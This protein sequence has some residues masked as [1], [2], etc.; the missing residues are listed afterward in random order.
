MSAEVGRL[1][2]AVVVGAGSV[3]GAALPDEPAPLPEVA[4]PVVVVEALCA[5]AEPATAVATAPPARA[6]RPAQSQATRQGPVVLD[7]RLAGIGGFRHAAVLGWHSAALLDGPGRPGGATVPQP[8]RR[9][10]RGATLEVQ[11]GQVGHPAAGPLDRLRPALAVQGGPGSTVARGR[12]AAATS[13]IPSQSSVARPARKPAPRVV[14]S[15]TGEI[16]TTRWTA[17]ATAWTK[18]GLAL[19]PPSTRST[20]IASPESASAASTRS[21]PRWATP[22]STAR[23]S[24]GRPVP[25]VRP[26][27]VPRAPKSQ[28]G[29]AQA[30]QGGDVDDA[31]GVG[32][33]A[34]HG[35]ALRGVGQDAEVVDQPFDVGPGREHD[36]LGPPGQLAPDRPGHDGERAVRVALRRSPAPQNRC[37]CRASRPCR[38]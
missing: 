28:R 23:T 19:I 11:R 33:R 18:V 22:S 30:Q 8:S 1:G 9:W 14:A 20:S 36:R 27:R 32:A 38:R 6:A 4:E 17:S 12:H 5:K 16:S 29:R 25:R 34:G 7:G 10:Q 24:S 2:G 13:S 21:A 3:L 37:R 15:V 31:T 35:V 26:S